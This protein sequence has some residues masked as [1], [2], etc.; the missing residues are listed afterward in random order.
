MYMIKS[1]PRL[2]KVKQGPTDR[3]ANHSA[4]VTD[5]KIEWERTEWVREEFCFDN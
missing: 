1:E 5:V 3:D 2:Q 4:G